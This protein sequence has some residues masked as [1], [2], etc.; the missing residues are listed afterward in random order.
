MKE[1][2]YL[3][4]AALI[5]VWWVGLA[6]SQT[7]FDAFQFSEISPTAFWAFFAPDV[8][9]IAT[10]S[11]VRAYRH[12]VSIEYIILGAFSYAAFLLL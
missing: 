1:T 9:L 11:T 8:I 2:A 6:S 10:L 4:Q 12:I 7:F 5:S 3:L